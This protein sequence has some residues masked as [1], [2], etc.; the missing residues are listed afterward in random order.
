MPGGRSIVAY[1]IFLKHG[2]HGKNNFELFMANI[3]LR[4]NMYRIL[5]TPTLVLWWA[6]LQTGFPGLHSPYLERNSLW[7][8]T[9]ERI[10]CMGAR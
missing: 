3:G 5:Q 8:L 7:M 4:G 6:G 10:V 1:L 9:T 2:P